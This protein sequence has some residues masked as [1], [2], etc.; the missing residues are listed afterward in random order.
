MGKGREALRAL[1]AARGIGPL[2]VSVSWH[3]SVCWYGSKRVL[4]LRRA[5]I[6]CAPFANNWQLPALDHMIDLP[7]ANSSARGVFHAARTLYQPF[8]DHFRYLRRFPFNPQRN[9][10]MQRSIGWFYGVALGGARDL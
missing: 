2:P 1:I 7:S 6:H 9:D 3:A 8:Q 5:K 10:A 4:Q